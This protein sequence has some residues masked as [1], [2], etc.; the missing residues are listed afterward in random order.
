MG[1]DEMS[2][3]THAGQSHA[4][5]QAVATL[6]Y[7]CHTAEVLELQAALQRGSIA[8]WTAH[9]EGPLEDLLA[10]RCINGHDCHCRVATRMY[11]AQHGCSESSILAGP[12]EGRAGDL[13]RGC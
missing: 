13:G 3:H 7:G 1:M 4:Q 11:V 5:Q 8:N 6:R 9:Q 2:E 10:P 12:T